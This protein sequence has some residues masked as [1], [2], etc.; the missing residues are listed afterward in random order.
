MCVKIYPRCTDNDTCTYI[1]Q[2][3]ERKG[4]CGL[5]PTHCGPLKTHSGL[6]WYRDANPVSTSI[7]A[8]RFQCIPKFAPFSR[9]LQYRP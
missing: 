5:T 9:C 7:N 4:C 1:M 2:S 8:N 6:C 3:I